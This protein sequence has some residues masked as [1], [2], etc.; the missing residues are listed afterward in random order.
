[1]SE[2]AWKSATELAGLI[3]ARRLG[4]RELL[5]H[6]IAIALPRALATNSRTAHA[7]HSLE[8]A[9]IRDRF[10]DHL[11]FGR[12]AVERPKPA[13]DLFLHAAN[14]MEHPPEACIVFEDSDAGV[15]AAHAAG[16]TVVH[17]P[18]QRAPE[19]DLADHIAPSLLD[20]AKW[21][22]LIQI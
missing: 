3:R 13:P 20:G 4:S 12:D 21:A 11:I 15:A 14:A 16:M 18:D 7:Q 1:M 9:G 5:D 8:R 10:S 17:I 6:L 22:G 19:T 2:I